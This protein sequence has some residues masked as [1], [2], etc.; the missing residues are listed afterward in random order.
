[1]YNRPVTCLHPNISDGTE[2]S[3]EH[4]KQPL[5]QE[6]YESLAFPVA[7]IGIV[8]MCNNFLVIYLYYRLKRLRTPSNLLLVNISL[9][10]FLFSFFGGGFTFML[11]VGR[12]WIVDEAACVFIGFTKNLFGLTSVFTLTIFVYKQYIQVMYERFVDFSWSWRAISCIWIYSLFWT[13]TPLIG[14]NRYTFEIHGLDCSLNWIPR[15][16]NEISFILFFFL[17]CLVVPLSIISYSYGHILYVIRKLQGIPKLQIN[18]EIKILNY[19]IKV[20]KMYGL[21]ILP[22]LLCWMPYTLISLLA[23]SGYGSLI[24]PT[25]SMLPSFFAKLVAAFNPVLYI[26]MIK[27]FRQGTQILCFQ[28]LQ[29]LLNGRHRH[30]NR[31]RPIGISQQAGHGMKK[32][33]WFSSSSTSCTVS[34]VQTETHQSSKETKVNAMNAKLINVQPI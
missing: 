29:R 16:P 26:F 6:T 31:I 5:T 23:T 4:H 19:E 15:G 34:T 1:M 8:G 33:I 10:D 9:S 28:C 13:A 20:A 25:N 17:A 24:T 2:V 30:R 21:T 12:Q 27:K 11:C 3:W 22:F 14:W 32:K 7:A 18:Q